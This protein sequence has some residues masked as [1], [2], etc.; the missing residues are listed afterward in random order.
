MKTNPRPSAV[1]KLS[2]HLPG[3]AGWILLWLIGVPV[4]LLLIFFLLR[5]CH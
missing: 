1:E 2:G 4:P 3:K 5:G